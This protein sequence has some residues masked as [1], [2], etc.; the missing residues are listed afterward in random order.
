M[1]IINKDQQLAIEN[2]IATLET[3][4]DAEFVAVVARR[5][6]NYRY[7][8]FL[9][10]AVAAL[11]IPLPALLTPFWLTTLDVLL[12]QWALFILLSLLFSIPALRIRLIP[13]SV[14]YWR[15]ANMARRQFLEN[16]LH[17]TQGETGVLLFIS[18]AER[19]VEI[20]ADRGINRLV[21]QTEWQALIDNFVAA[22][23]AG[24]THEG[25]VSCINGCGE[26][27]KQH[28]PATHQRDE[29]PNHLVMI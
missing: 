18:E 27:L 9:W 20:I 2:L 17:H 10:A 1:T 6:D 7:I 4:T 22:V 8:A 16:N 3:H 15:A 26:I 12:V 25:L 29:L 28:V 23:A 13:K 24:K 19:Y 21:A 5:S 14:R 11:L